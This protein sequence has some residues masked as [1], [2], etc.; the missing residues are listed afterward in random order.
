MLAPQ[1]EHV[2]IR[3]EYKKEINNNNNNNR[4]A[5]SGTND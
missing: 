1:K 3:K 5:F 4:H 2:N